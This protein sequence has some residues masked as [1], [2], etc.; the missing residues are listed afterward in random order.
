MKIK[1]LFDAANFQ[2][3]IKGAFRLITAKMRANNLHRTLLITSI[4]GFSSAI[5][6][7]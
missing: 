7:S 2:V 4:L 6:R 3:L 1:L 5:F